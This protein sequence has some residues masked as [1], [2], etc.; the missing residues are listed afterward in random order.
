MS[1]LP[2]AVA[3][4]VAEMRSAAACGFDAMPPTLI[5]WADR[6]QSALDA[7]PEPA[8]ISDHC[9]LVGCE[10]KVAGLPAW[11]LGD[12]VVTTNEAGDCVAVTRQD[13]D[14]RVLSVLWERPQVDAPPAAV[15]EGMVLVPRE[16]TEAQWSGLAR[17]IMMWLDFD[18]SQKTPRYLFQYLEWSGVDI[19]EWLRKESEMQALDHVPS[20]GARCAIIYKAML[21]AAKE[22]SHD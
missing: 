8:S 3:E 18:P 4:V 21:A 2:E 13:A 22:P 5:Q 16:P 1:T 14:H 7:A 11:S 15:P 10:H 9:R 17:S 19:P 12:V 20:K 6:L